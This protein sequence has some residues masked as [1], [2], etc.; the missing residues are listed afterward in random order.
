MTAQP[1]YNLPTVPAALAG[2]IE[3]ALDIRWSWSHSSD[4]LWKELAPELWEATHNP[5]H[6]LQTIAQ[7]RLEEEA[8][9]PEFLG[10]L[11]SHVVA[12]RE[13][14]EARTWFIETYPAAAGLITCDQPPA[15]PLGYPFSS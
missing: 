1:R 11:E 7:T 8:T 12:R 10:L 6:I 3:L 14:L 4:V 15:A 13:T 2:L 5:W 9:D